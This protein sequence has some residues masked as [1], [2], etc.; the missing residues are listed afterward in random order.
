MPELLR[1]IIDLLTPLWP[2][3]IVW[4]WQR[5]LY[6]IAGR[7]M[8]EVGPGVKAVVPYIC[9]VKCVSIVPEIYTTP[10]QTITLRDKSNLTY[11]AS[12]TVVVKNP[13]AAYNLIGHYEETIVELAARILS[14]GLADAD[15]ERFDPARGKRERV[16]DELRQE[17][18]KAASLYGLEITGLGMNNFARNVRTIRLL[19][20]RAVL[21]EPQNRS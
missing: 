13:R 15:P 3:R 10:L 20:D 12:L 5:G 1:L 7:C 8:G 16:I 11:S 19:L 9:D 2:L 14:D 18:N 6:Y 17:I 21:A 4:E